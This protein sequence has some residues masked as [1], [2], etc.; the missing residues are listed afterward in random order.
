MEEKILTRDI[1]IKLLKK[2]IRKHI[3][4]KQRHI[5]EHFKELGYT[6]YLATYSSGSSEYKVKPS[7]KKTPIDRAIFT[8]VLKP[9]RERNMVQKI[10]THVY[11]SKVH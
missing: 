8:Q 6:H 5:R 1:A 11:E 3:T 7:Y 2:F 4:F 9:L 10:S